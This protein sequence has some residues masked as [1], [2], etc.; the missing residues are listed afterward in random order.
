MASSALVAAAYRDVGRNR[1]LRHA[2]AAFLLFNAQE[3]AI[4]IAVTLYAFARGG[5]SVAGAVLVL[6]LVVAAVVA[7]IG[8][9][10][11]DRI[12]RDRALAL[13]YGVQAL[14]SLSLGLALWFAPA[15]I[16]YA[17]AVLSSCSMT[18]SRP[19]HNAVLPQIADTPEQ[20]TAANSLSATTESLGLLLGPLL[21]SV[22]I[23]L[24]GPALVCVV[25][26]VLMMLASCL[27]HRMRLH[28]VRDATAGAPALVMDA[29]EAAASPRLLTDVA[30]GWRALR[31]DPPAAVLTFFAGAQYFVLGVLDIFYV[32]LA[33]DVLGI[34]EQG[35]GLLAA[36]I[37]AGGLVGAAA[38]AM[39]VG[40]RRFA[41]PIEIAVGV[42]AGA[43][44][45][46]SLSA[47]FGP[48]IGLLIV[49]G[50]ARV[51]FDVG[52]RTLLQRSLPNEVLSRVFGLQEALLML[53]TA[54]GSAAAPS[55]IATF[56]NQGAFVAV[57]VF[58]IGLGVVALPALRS[59]DRRAVLPD[60]ER[61]ALLRSIPMFGL[62]SQPR[63]ERILAL[64]QPVR[65]AE[66]ELVIRRGEVG[67]RFYIVAGGEVVVRVNGH[68]VARHGRGGYVGEIALLR[69]VPRTADVVA[70][71]D[72]ELFALEREDF[73]L[74]LTGSRRGVRMADA[75]V[76]RRLSELDTLD[77]D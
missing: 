58:V 51:F 69:D 66:G 55:L 8:A 68:E 34:G 65:V 48:T 27:T 76:D 15:S 30:E 19:V 54:L 29:S 62:L 39:L 56:G 71:T 38:T 64:L 35:A 46:I 60:P 40:R 43:T 57:G 14:S 72:V 42:M 31:L 12:R 36:A 28:P 33:I 25:M 41:S 63:L 59:L 21:N 5:A 22:L 10:L 70:E 9:V 67:E 13:G 52:A 24:S 45:A 37:G 7:P 77:E 61:L 47:A 20:L 74:A 32:V 2:L 49:A 75:E 6:Q 11:G 18:L 73:L 53:A 4:W 16:V 3:Y 1:S 50:A 23:A 26:G 44:A 17:T